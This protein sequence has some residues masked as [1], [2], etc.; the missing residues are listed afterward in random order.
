MA[1]SII[2]TPDTFI[3]PPIEFGNETSNTTKQFENIKNIVIK[4]M[5]EQKKELLKYCVIKT[6]L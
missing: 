6:N 4:F 2:N 5:N 3:P 1:N